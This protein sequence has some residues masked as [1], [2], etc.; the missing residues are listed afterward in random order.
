MNNRKKI[1][2]F[3]IGGLSK[4]V[5]KKL[6]DQTVLDFE[7]FSGLNFMLLERVFIDRP[8]FLI[9][10]CINEYFKLSLWVKVVLKFFRL[11]VVIVL[12]T[13]DERVLEVFSGFR[14]GLVNF[15]MLKESD[16][17]I[18]VGKFII[19]SR[20][21]LKQL[22]Q[23]TFDFPQVQ[24][25]AIGSS[26]GGTTGLRRIFS[27]LP[28]LTPPV[29]VV[30]HFHGGLMDFFVKNLDLV[31]KITVKQAEKNEV[32][33]KSHAYLAVEGQHLVVKQC[34]HR[35]CL[36]FLPARAA[37]YRFVPSIDLFFSSVARVFGKNSLGIILN[38]L[39]D[40]GVRGMK[41]IKL[42]GGLTIAIAC[43]G[44]FADTMPL[45]AVRNNAVDLVLTMDEIAIFVKYLVLA[46]KLQKMK[47]AVFSAGCFWAVEYYFRQL[48]GV[49][50][51][52][53][54][55]TGG[56]TPNPTYEEVSKGTTGHVEAV[57]VK[58]DPDKISYEDL[59]KYFFEIH[60][61]TQTNG[62]GPDVGPQYLSNIFYQD[63]SE[64]DTALKLINKLFAKGYNVATGL[65]KFEKF[66]PAE[67][68]HHR[69]YEKHHKKPAYHIHRPINWESD[70]MDYDLGNY[71]PMDPMFF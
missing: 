54:G 56:K 44:V 32:L 22:S 20:L 30:Q 61:F 10:C 13:V 43:D 40:D 26:A 27:E 69:Y 6:F 47:T 41:Q 36:D 34:L 11:P 53:P 48:P 14:C 15:F 19:S 49:I 46:Q 65:I 57:L 45:S 12:E 25:I 24:V 9:F 58:Y 37:D 50:D 63:Q 71:F 35:F 16:L 5:L 64:Y 21:K 55:Y 8:Q 70:E 29:V 52:I 38:G 39:S 4:N 7:V 1:S 33:R 18:K 23:C 59:V 31:S 60:D 28:S 67:E 2:G 3:V 42:A 51:V 68:Y 17:A 66:W 62:Q